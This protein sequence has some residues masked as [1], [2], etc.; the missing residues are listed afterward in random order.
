[1]GLYIVGSYADSPISQTYMGSH[2]IQR[3][4]NT[5]RPT[6]E[7]IG[8]DHCRFDVTIAQQFLNSSNVIPAFEQVGSE[9]IGK[10]GDF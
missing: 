7:H 8:I 5:R 9:R 10:I 1:M 6:V 4:A 3:T 2:P